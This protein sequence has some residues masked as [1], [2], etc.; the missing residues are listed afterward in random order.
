[1]LFWTKISHSTYSMNLNTNWRHYLVF[2]LSTLTP[3]L[4]ASMALIKTTK[5]KLGATTVELRTIP[6]LALATLRYTCRQKC[7]RATLP[8]E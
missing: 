7:I 2:E 5:I 8:G 6:S 3:Y 1:M 4:N